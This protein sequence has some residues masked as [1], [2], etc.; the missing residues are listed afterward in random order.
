VPFEVLAA[1]AGA[2]AEPT[3]DVLD[4]FLAIDFGAALGLYCL[5]GQLEADGTG[6]ALL[7]VH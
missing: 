2:L 5:L 1:A 3:L 4:A 7:E 6:K